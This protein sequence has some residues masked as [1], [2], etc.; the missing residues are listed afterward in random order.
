M[1]TLNLKSYYD[2]EDNVYSYYEYNNE[3]ILSFIKFINAIIDYCDSFYYIG[4]KLPNNLDNTIDCENVDI[5]VTH[6]YNNT[7]EYYDIK[8]AKLFNISNIKNKNIL[9]QNLRFNLSDPDDREPIK[10][11]TDIEN[12]TMSYN[13]N[14]NIIFIHDNKILFNFYLYDGYI[15]DYCTKLDK[16]KI[17]KNLT[18]S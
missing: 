16:D 15:Y 10:V 6:Y 5:N 17:E 1:K 3:D 4:D 2:N 18:I 7:K 9:K 13:L 12:I 8:G 14:T 11:E